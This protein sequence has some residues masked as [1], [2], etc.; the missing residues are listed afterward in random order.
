MKKL[1]SK[2]V[3]ELIR[4]AREWGVSGYSKL[5]KAELVKLL[6]RKRPRTGDGERRKA[7]AGEK[8]G[9]ARTRASRARIGRGRAA[10]ASPQIEPL[11]GE[12][13]PQAQPPQAPPVAAQPQRSGGGAAAPLPPRYGDGRMGLL[14]R[15]AHW[16]YCFW[17]LSPVQQQR[18]R[19]A[20]AAALRVVELGSSA[21]RELRRIPL[22]AGASS[23]YVQV[24]AADRTYRCDLGW[25]SGN[26]GF[27]PWLSSNPS[28]TPPDS[29]WPAAPAAA[30]PRQAPAADPPPAPAAA[31]AAASTDALERLALGPQP[32]AADSAA[33]QQQR[34]PAAAADSAGALDQRRPPPAAPASQQLQSAGLAAERRAPDVGYWL[35]VDA[36]VI[37]YGATVPGSRV[38][39]GDL[40]LELDDEGH[41]RA[42]L[43]F[44]DGEHALEV[45]GSGPE[46]DQRR[47]R[48]DLQRRTRD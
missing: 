27:E 12:S 29:A 39:L 30:T 4:L 34:R 26:G 20:G 33:A 45:L 5:K 24:D 44:P 9:R 28:T 37:I 42:R 11:V 40:P 25:P 35:R 36:D 31:P 23:W 18:W 41:F 47:V 48:L 32:A 21:D 19:E 3:K 15:D 8:A 14:P 7:A 38:H 22:P 43:A 6:T 2:T 16:L 17:D 1:E 10:Y 13:R 46:G